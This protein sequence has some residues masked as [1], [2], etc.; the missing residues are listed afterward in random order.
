MHEFATYNGQQITK[1]IYQ[2]QRQLKRQENISRQITVLT[3]K[4]LIP[5]RVFSDDGN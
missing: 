5:A 2:V 3:T 1:A 4:V